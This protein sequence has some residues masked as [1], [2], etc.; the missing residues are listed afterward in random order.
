MFLSLF[1]GR[2]RSFRLEVLTLRGH[3]QSREN[4]RKRGTLFLTATLRGDVD[5]NPGFIS[6]PANHN[7]PIC[8]GQISSVDP[9]PKIKSETGDNCA[10]LRCWKFPWQKKWSSTF[11]STPLR[12]YFAIN[13][14]AAVQ[15]RRFS[16][17]TPLPSES[18]TNFICGKHRK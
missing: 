18:Q 12:L 16:C 17:Q 3:R 9:G 1:L 6:V 11:K 7:G 15:L 8:N 13:L 4:A 2:E 14:H 10:Q 5:P